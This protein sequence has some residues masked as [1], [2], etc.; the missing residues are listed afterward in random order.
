MFKKILLP[1]DG[2]EPAL[3]AVDMGI[4]L[5]ARLGA[6]GHAFHVMEPFASVEYFSE[7]LVFPEGAYTEKAEAYAESC[8]AKVCRRARLAGV[9]CTSSH[10]LDHRPYSAIAAAAARL[11]C[12]LIVMGTQGRRG[13]DVLLLGSQTHKTILS[14]EVPVLVCR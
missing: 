10:E 7:L 1:T 13:L 3:R 11:Q 4:A 9:P 2:S 12:D 5:A 14:A 8:V 6:Q